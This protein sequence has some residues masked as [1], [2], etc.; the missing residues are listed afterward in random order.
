M[1]GKPK[2]QQLRGEAPARLREV[3]RERDEAVKRIDEL[4]AELGYA[5]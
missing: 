1:A 5:R 4:P 3:E 2:R